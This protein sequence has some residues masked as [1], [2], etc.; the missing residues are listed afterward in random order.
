MLVAASSCSDKVRIN[1]KVEGLPE[2]KI[3]IK[4]LSGSGF[5]VLDTV[6]T[7][8]SG[9][10][11][12]KMEVK[13]GQPE[14]VYIFDGDTKLASLILQKGDKVK[15]VSDS[16]GVYT[17][18]GSEESSKLKEVEDEFSAFMKDFASSVEAG[19][20]VAASRKYVDYYRS[21][22]KYVVSNSK[23]L[24]AI[25]V[26]YQKVNDDF[27]VFSL[28][29]DAVLFRGIH[30][31]L[32]TVY[33]DSRYVTALGKEAE[34][35]LNGLSLE[36][37]LRDAEEAG[38]PDLELPGIDGKARRLSDIDAKLIMVFF[39]QASDA[40]H[41]MFNQEV[42]L[43]LYKTY[44]PKGLE[45]YSIS[46]DT[47]KGVW[48]SAVRNQELPWINV[49]D[50]RGAGTPAVALYN[51]TNDLPVAYMIIDGS[52]QPVSM[53]TDQELRAFMAANLK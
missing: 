45:I 3:V 21:R 34:R 32:M 4:Q 5:N 39:W 15:V 16:K 20:N 25:P 31:S 53:S 47:D 50:G 26:L 40:V 43:P 38:F 8:A 30:D 23:S 1:G 11:S 22:V 42:L 46:L 9:A 37:R 44:H 2:S 10:Y 41:K 18:E 7:D 52:L 17:V 36:Q 24:A 14:F 19:D 12:Y 33:P 28:G 35:R 6:K 27:P 29:T 48:A 51:L 13:E 49:C